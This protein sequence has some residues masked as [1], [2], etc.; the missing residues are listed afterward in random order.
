M[1]IKYYHNCHIFYHRDI[2]AS[3]G[4]CQYL[5]IYSRRRSRPAYRES[6]DLV[7]DAEGRYVEELQRD[8]QNILGKAIVAAL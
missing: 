2:M 1:R 7:Q 4:Y 6:Y 8:S 5:K 3:N